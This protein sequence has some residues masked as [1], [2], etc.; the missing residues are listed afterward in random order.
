MLSD[1]E[2]AVGGA[3]LSLIDGREKNMPDGGVMTLSFEMTAR[4]SHSLNLPTHANE[5]ISRKDRMIFMLFQS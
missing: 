3:K 1:G 2:K 5:A 4:V